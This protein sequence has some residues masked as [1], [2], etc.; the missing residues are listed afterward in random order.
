MGAGGHIDHSRVRD[1]DQR[2]QQQPGQGEVPEVIS[3]ELHLVAVGAL[4]AWDR[5]DAGVI[6][7]EIESGIVGGDQDSANVRTDVRSAEVQS[8]DLEIARLGPHGL[9]GCVALGHIP[10]R[11]SDIGAV[12]CER[13]G[14]VE[15][16][17][18]I[19]TRDDGGATGE[20]GHV[21]DAPAVGVGRLVELVDRG[22]ISVVNPT[23]G[24]LAGRGWRGRTRSTPVRFTGFTPQ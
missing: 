11:E 24:G 1:G 9:D 15:A 13:L 18:G 16:D 22:A 21:S 5:H 2:W 7:Q 10:Y 19:G 23:K 20:V 3:G 12:A 17:T 14:C 8:P 4:P 6:D